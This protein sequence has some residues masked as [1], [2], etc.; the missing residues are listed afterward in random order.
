E[1]ALAVWVIKT[2]RASKPVPP[3]AQADDAGGHCQLL[4]E[5]PAGSGNWRVSYRGSEWDATVLAGEASPG[6]AAVIEAREG[7]TLKIRIH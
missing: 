3:E 7:S 1:A 2:R 6:K 5:N 4:R